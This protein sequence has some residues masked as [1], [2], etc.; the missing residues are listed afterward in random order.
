MKKALLSLA[1]LTAS[2]VAAPVAFF[3]RSRK[4]QNIPPAG[5]P[6]VD[7]GNNTY[8][9]NVGVGGYIQ[10]LSFAMSLFHTAS[11]DGVVSITSPLSPLLKSSIRSQ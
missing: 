4:R 7:L 5:D 9:I 11:G 3:I 8:S 6:W 2:S 10:D 1:L